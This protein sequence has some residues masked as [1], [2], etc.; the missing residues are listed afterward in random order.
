MDTVG[1]TGAAVTMWVKEVDGAVK[2]VTNWRCE[3]QGSERAYH[4]ELFPDFARA[5]EFYPQEQWRSVHLGQVPVEPDRPHLLQI[6]RSEESIDF[7]VDGQR[8]PL[9]SAPDL[10]AC[11][12]MKEWALDFDI[13][14][15]GSAEGHVDQASVRP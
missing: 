12:T 2:P 10:P 15:G 5:V 14:A 4:I 6:E 3:E 7:Y 11:F 1:A 13:E 8:L 9:E